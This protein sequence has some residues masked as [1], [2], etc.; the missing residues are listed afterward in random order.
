[1]S[2][3]I[4]AP[5]FIVRLILIKDGKTLLLKRKSSKGGGYSLI[6]GKVDDGEKLIDALKREV[7]EESGIRIKK[8]HLELIHI[9][10][11]RKHRL[12]TVSLFYLTHKWA[13][14]IQNLE[15]LNCEIF[16][17]FDLKNLPENITPNTRLALHG[18]LKKN[19]YSEFTP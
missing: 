1:M 10:N 16:E 17:W 12:H 6:G 4:K 7:L 13:G 18:L 14:K 11:R 19:Y 5:Q 9:V 8:K 2:T 15:P 3:P